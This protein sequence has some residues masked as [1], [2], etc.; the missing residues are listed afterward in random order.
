MKKDT[1]IIR[2]TV[3]EHHSLNVNEYSNV[4][5]QISSPKFQGKN[6]FKSKFETWDL[7]YPKSTSPLPECVTAVNRGDCN[8]VEW[9]F[10]DL[11]TF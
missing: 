4:K 8:F 7:G 10:I 1:R 11:Q 6:K 9:N 2:F 5:S 3:I